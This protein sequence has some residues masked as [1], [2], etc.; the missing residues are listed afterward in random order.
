[1]DFYL[2][3]VYL[4]LGMTVTS[5]MIFTFMVNSNLFMGFL[6]D[7]SHEVHS[8]MRYI[9]DYDIEQFDNVRAISGTVVLP[10]IRDAGSHDLAIFVQTRAQ[11]GVIV[12]YGV[13]LRGTP[14]TGSLAHARADNTSGLGTP[15]RIWEES[16]VFSARSIF[17]RANVDVLGTITPSSSTSND[18]MPNTNRETALDLIYT[19]MMPMRVGKSADGDAWDTPTISFW[20]IHHANIG[21]A[22][23]NGDTFT[24][25]GR[26]FTAQTPRFTMN[27]NHN[28]IWATTPGSPYYVNMTS[29]FHSAFIVD[30]RGIVVGIY[31]E[32]HG[33]HINSSLLAQAQINIGLFE[34]TLPHTP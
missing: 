17:G 33:V 1:M 10:L 12:N 22:H 14:N 19:G 9:L 8:H 2:K 27:R 34:G 29:Q 31:F 18:N 25:T 6:D 28:V 20:N 21:V 23:R 11:H 4:L 26:L 13:Q 32:E 5:V 7:T 3:V 16:F 24:T 30:E 15:Q